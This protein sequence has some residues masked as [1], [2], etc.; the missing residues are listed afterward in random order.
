MLS[1]LCPFLCSC[2]KGVMEKKGAKGIK[3]PVSVPVKSCV[4]QSAGPKV[5]PLVGQLS[6]CWVICGN[7]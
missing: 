5:C 1:E 2:R 4:T 3:K 7:I 6:E